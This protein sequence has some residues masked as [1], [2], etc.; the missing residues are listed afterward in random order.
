MNFYDQ[1]L[2]YFNLKKRSAPNNE[3]WVDYGVFLIFP[4]AYS[5][6]ENNKLN[7]M[8][9]G[10]LAAFSMTE[11][12]YYFVLIAFVW[13][14]IYSNSEDSNHFDKVTK[15]VE[16][17]TMIQLFH[18]QSLKEKLELDPTL[19]TLNYKNKSLLYWS[20]Y[21]ENFRAHQMI[22]DHIKIAKQK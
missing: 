15:A 20:K 8:M 22:I 11:W 7:K 21:Y 14:R 18:L 13:Y 16:L 17:V 1:T 12:K 3:N 4:L 5:F 6:V 10:T 19:A 2:E 9:I